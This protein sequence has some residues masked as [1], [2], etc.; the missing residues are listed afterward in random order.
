MLVDIRA[1]GILGNHKLLK[2]A[3][4]TNRIM[5]N[6]IFNN[7]LMT[8]MGMKPPESLDVVRKPLHHSPR[9]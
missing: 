9:T 6:C 2:Q 1:D 7:N 5:A 8:D 3:K 4:H